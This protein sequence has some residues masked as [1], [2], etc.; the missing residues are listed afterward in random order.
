MRRAFVE[1]LCNLAGN[2][3]RVI[4]LTGDLGFQV[5][6]DFIAR[7]SSRYINVGIAEAQMVNM[8]AG[9][10]KEGFRPVVYSIAS[11]MTARPFEQIRITIAY[12]GL[13]VVI[14][15]AGGGYCYAK[16]GVTHHAPDDIGLMS[17]LPGMTVT[18]PGDPGEV[19][20]L[21]PQLVNLDQ[22][23]YMRIGKFGEPSYSGISPIQLGQARTLRVG[24]RI[25][26]ITTGEMA[27]P[28][29]AVA[30]RLCQQCGWA[31]EVVQFHTI[32]P[33]DESALTRLAERFSRF[34][35]LEEVSPRG[36]LAASIA[37]WI[38]YTSTPVK[39][40]RMGPPDR[41]TMGN[42]TIES[43][44]RAYRYNADAVFEAC[45]ATASESRVRS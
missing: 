36:G 3:P 34:V 12:A 26:L 22:P 35:V 21:L 17:L 33:M 45:R 31:P 41:F 30:D 28:A 43:L 27:V 15:G 1:S 6:D 4:L 37:S 44:R 23:S 2:D 24:S 29:L 40:S 19:R 9:L 8:A 18:A 32:K 13:P 10:A 38:L 42:P 14:V 5:F 39:L 11:F 16:S 7:F 25:A 20:V